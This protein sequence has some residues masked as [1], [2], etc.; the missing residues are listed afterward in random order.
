MDG[1]GP[2]EQRTQDQKLED[3]HLWCDDDQDTKPTAAALVIAA[4]FLV[5]I[6]VIAATILAT[7]SSA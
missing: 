7:G 6:S 2:I 1:N 3:F 4:V 5:V